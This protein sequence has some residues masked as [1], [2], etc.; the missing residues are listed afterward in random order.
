MVMGDKIAEVDGGATQNTRSGPT[1][2]SGVFC[3]GPYRAFARSFFLN[4]RHF[5][6][7]PNRFAGLLRYFFENI[8][9]ASSKV[10]LEPMSY[11]IPGTV[12]V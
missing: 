4:V 7:H 2:D 6:L 10:S 9:L 5:Q 8:R 1:T 12:H 11:Q 3:A